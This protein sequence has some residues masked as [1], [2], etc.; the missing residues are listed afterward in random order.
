MK[1]KYRA[2]RKD[3]F[4]KCRYEQK[5]ETKK[6]HMVPVGPPS[7]LTQRVHI[8]A[9]YVDIYS[10]SREQNFEYSD[11]PWVNIPSYI[12]SSLPTPNHYL[13]IHD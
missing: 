11:R 9:R 13:N 3:I 1:L 6:K 5:G 7:T 12:I 10:G 2:S 8:M 4:L